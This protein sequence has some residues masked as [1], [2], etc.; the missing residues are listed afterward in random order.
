M[1]DG[2]L[3]E[4]EIGQSRLRLP[5]VKLAD[6]AC[7]P[8]GNLSFP[9]GCAGERLGAPAWGSLTNPANG[10]DVVSAVRRFKADQQSNADAV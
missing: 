8:G 9:F 2:L 7:Q 1:R 4:G 6:K 3:E 5:S 10:A